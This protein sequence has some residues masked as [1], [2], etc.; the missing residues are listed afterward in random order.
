MYAPLNIEQ[1]PDPTIPCTPP[2]SIT[3]APQKKST[4]WPKLTANDFLRHGYGTLHRS[5]PLR[6]LSLNTKPFSECSTQTTPPNP[7]PQQS[8]RCLSPCSQD[9]ASSAKVVLPKAPVSSTMSFRTFKSK[10]SNRTR[11]DLSISEL[12]PFPSH[13]QYSPP[14]SI[15]RPKGQD[16]GKGKEKAIALR[17]ATPVIIEHEREHPMSAEEWQLRSEQRLKWRQRRKLEL[18]TDRRVHGEHQLPLD[19]NCNSSLGSTGMGLAPNARGHCYSRSSG[20]GTKLLRNSSSSGL[21]SPTSQKENSP[22]G[23]PR[24]AKCGSDSVDNLAAHCAAFRITGKAKVPGMTRFLCTLLSTESM[25]FRF[26]Y[27]TNHIRSS[28]AILAR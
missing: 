4:H 21:P 12:N 13:T 2:A 3:G 25:R 1:Y 5:D 8:D 14:S 28:N 23:T 24:P 22:C 17:P 10:Q 26:F 6:R 16:S 27:L 19:I 9:F 15:P 7:S 20:S 11:Q 18:S